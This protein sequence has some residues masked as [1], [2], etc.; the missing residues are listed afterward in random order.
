ME[1]PA[2]VTVLDITK[3]IR[4]EAAFIYPSRTFKKKHGNGSVTT[5]LL[6]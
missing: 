3:V 6:Y 1:Q 4:R 2:H 5:V